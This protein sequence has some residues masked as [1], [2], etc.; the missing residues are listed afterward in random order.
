MAY[1]LYLGD[2]QL[3]IAPPSLEL[4]VRNQNKTVTLINEGEIN[5]LKSPGL[6]E[7]KFD[8]RI[9]QTRYPFADYPGGFEGAAVFLEK[10]EAHKVSKKPFQ[11]ICVRYSPDGKML[12]DTNIQVSLEE[13]SILE[14]ADEGF[15]VIVSVELE[16][17]KA[18]G[19]K[20]VTVPIQQE[21]PVVQVQEQRPA[22]SASTPKTYTVVSGDCL[23]NIAKK[24]LGDGSRYPEIYSLNRDKIKDPNLIYPGQVLT[25]P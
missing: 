10:L 12:F 11:F 15:D 21:K 6:T 1:T 5:L 9:P 17:Y 16:Q 4:K 14:D 20:T 19:T 13:Y 18:Y 24:F 25:L 8:M 22:F 7:I 3:P 23:W 2:I